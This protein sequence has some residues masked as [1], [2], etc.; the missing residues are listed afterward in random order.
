MELEG[1]KRCFS[2]IQEKA[3]LSIPVFISDRHSAISKWIREQHPTTKHF[4]DIW[5]VAKT[6]T[7]RI[8]KASKKH[9]CEILKLWTKA[10]K[11]HLYW[12]VTS[13]KKGFDALIEGKWLSLIRHV[14]N[15]YSEHPN[16]LFSDCT[17]A[18]LEPRE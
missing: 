1:A 14:S 10:I 3:I 11:N 15:K 9:G 5:H 4:Y 12:C 7:K 2:F 6:V 8:L 16:E 17:H 18:D 13:T